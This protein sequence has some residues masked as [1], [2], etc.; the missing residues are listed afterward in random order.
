[1]AISGG[2]IF[3]LFKRNATT[4][5]Q[6]NTHTYSKRIYSISFK[7]IFFLKKKKR[8]ANDY[9]GCAGTVMAIGTAS[10]IGDQ[11]LS[12]GISVAFNFRTNV[13][14]KR[15]FSLFKLSDK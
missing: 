1:M 2:N 13:F 5:K 14:A 9:R 8:K 3:L 12:S 4:H 6:R 10:G 11:I 7:L 15:I